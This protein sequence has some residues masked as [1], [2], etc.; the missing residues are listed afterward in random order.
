MNKTKKAS[1]IV[2]LLFLLIPLAGITQMHIDNL[3]YDRPAHEWTEALPV[4][5]GRLGAMVFGGVQEELIQLNESS[6]WSGGPIPKVINPDAAS[7]L[8]EIR[9]VLLEADFDKASALAKKMQGLFT[10]SYMPMGDLIIKQQF[11]DTAVTGY[12]RSLDIQNARCNTSYMAGGEFFTRTVYASAPDQVII[13]QIK[14]ITAGSLNLKV[15]ARS[16][17]MYTLSAAAN[18]EL[19]MKGK[20]PAHADPSYYKRNQAPIIW[21][22]STGANCSGMRYEMIVKAVNTGG[23]VTADTSGITIKSASD[24]VLYISAATSFNG[25]DKC[26]DKEGKDEHKL[27][28]GYLNA[29]LKYNVQQLIDRQRADHR[30]YYDRVTFHLQDTTLGYNKGIRV[31]K[32]SM[33]PS[34]KRLENYSAGAYD[35]GIEVLYFNYGRYLLLSCSRP[36]GIPANLQ[37]LWNKELRAPWSSNFTININTQMNY[38]PA[39]VTNLSEMHLPL[40]DLMNNLAVTGKRTTKE[41]YGMNGWVAHHNTDI[42]A[43]SNPVGNKGDGDPKWANWPQGGNWLCQHA[44]EHYSFTRDKK[45]LKNVAYPLMKGAAEFCLDWLVEDKD[46]Y[47]IMVPST[48]PENDF[49][50]GNGKTSGIGVATTMDMSIIW[51][52]FTNLIEACDV[53][54]IDKVFH[55][56]LVARKAKLYPLH[57]GSKGNLQE[58]N[59]DYEDVDPQHRHVSHLFGLHPGRQ[60]APVSTP[61]FAAAARRTLEIRGDEG[62]GWSKAW[63]INFWA[64]LLDGNHAYSLVR[65]L[66][67]YTGNSGT[68]FKR[69]GTYAN[70]FDAH[71]PFQIDGNFGGT[72]GMAEMLL[73]SH[74][75]EVHLLPALPDAWGEG[76]VSGLKARGNFDVSIHWKNHRLTNAL[77]VSNVGGI[78]KIRTA[79]PVTIVSLKI[80]SEKDAHGYV[81]TFDTKQGQTYLINSL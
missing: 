18:N 37:G 17:L 31:N 71:P 74:L 66:L 4:G 55:D 38:W 48:S 24:V 60:I 50:Y 49:K 54:G 62:T 59:K 46:G 32:N 47:L 22:D 53:L 6:L 61:E 13:I 65:Q 43:T 68:G 64:R 40:F 8:P 78:C 26:P 51:D 28:T 23:T 69:G 52:L 77:I 36:G 67:T 2:S 45:F 10:E 20:A 39:E 44:W 81:L 58:W 42:W 19:V 27:A 80:K 41:F 7:H 56:K 33:L 5:N 11:R 34:D 35:P 9:K 30:K 21:K 57:I 70:F 3:H 63:K 75:G 14:A 79:I 16:P 15:G 12:E 73:Q 29:A 1:C 25:F 72:A 76:S